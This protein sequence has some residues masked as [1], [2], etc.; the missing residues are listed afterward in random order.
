[1]KVLDY[2]LLLLLHW[3]PRVLSII[4]AVFVS[5][6][7]LDVFGQGTGF[8]KSLIA[9]I[10]HMIPT[11]L[12][13]I[14]LILSWKR[15]WIGGILFILMGILYIIWSGKSGRGSHIIDFPLFLIGVLFF[16]DW[17]LRKKIK[18]AQAMYRAD[19]Q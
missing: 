19:M 9:L 12:I 1:M 7:A 4:F 17:I 13:V 3:A 11:L 15:S 14:I 10:I 16:T 2:Y 8:V 5:L 18:Q 6:F